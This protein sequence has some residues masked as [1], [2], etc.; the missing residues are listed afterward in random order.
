MGDCLGVVIQM[1]TISANSL[2]RLN[3]IFLQGKKPISLK[4][5]LNI[6]FL[7]INDAVIEYSKKT[8]W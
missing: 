2:Q 7:L 5:K 3:A 8:L 1:L 6:V 4:S